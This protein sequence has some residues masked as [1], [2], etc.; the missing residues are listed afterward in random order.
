VN[1]QPPRFRPN[2]LGAV[3]LSVGASEAAVALKK[4]LQNVVAI[5]WRHFVL[6]DSAFKHWVGCPN[7][8]FQPNDLV[9]RL[10]AQALLVRPQ[11]AP[12]SRRNSSRQLQ[13]FRLGD[14]LAA[15][16]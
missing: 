14:S 12:R 16:S 15:W 8:R 3:S 4:I 5:G 7:L 9:A 2:L 1:R 6:A 11:Q 13:A 10:T